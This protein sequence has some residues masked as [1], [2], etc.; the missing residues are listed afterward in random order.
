MNLKKYIIALSATVV[1]WGCES[2]FLDINDD[3]NNPTEAPLSGLLTNIEVG[4]TGSLG[5]GSNSG[6]LSNYVTHLVGQHVTRG[7]LAD[8]GLTG[9]DFGVTNSWNNLY[10][11]ALQDIKQVEELAPAQE[12]YNYLGVAQILKAYIYSNMVDVWGN[13]PY[14]GANLGAANI[15]PTYDNGAVIYDSCFAL[16][17]QGIANLERTSAAGSLLSSGD[18]FFLNVS[19]ANKAD[20]WIRAANTLKLRLYTQITNVEDVSSQVSALLADNMLMQ[21][22]TDLELQYGSSSNP[23]NRNPLYAGE[24]ATAGSAHYIDPFF[25]EIMSGIN[26]FFPNED[27]PYTANNVIDPRIPYYF[28]N[29]MSTAESPEN[30]PAYWD[31]ATGFLGIYGFSFNIDPNEGFD[32]ASSQTI[33]G[34]WPGGGAVD[35]G[36][37]VNASFNGPGDTPQRLLTYYNL[38]FNRAELALNGFTSEDPRQMF[39][40]GMNAA[41]DK[42]DAYASASGASAIPAATRSIYTTAV[43]GLYDAAASDAERLEIIMIE[44]WKAN[45]G[46]GVVAYNDYR[47]TGFPR[48]HDGDTDNLSQTDRQREY[49]VSLPWNTNALEINPNAPSQKITATSRVFWD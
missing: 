32:Q 35:D 44:K 25:Y 3:P 16:L 21:P 37:G 18:V 5:M 29:Q 26:S 36:L 12:A 7:N 1:F 2:N 39:I 4:M 19:E 9:T 17:D 31:G 49:P 30:P 10:R 15:S 34:L 46:M 33:I 8:Y 23:D 14:T 22:G 38:L 43:T 47:R 27:N 48:L 20:A 24:W 11:V 41:F 40:D 13:V 45:Y 6:G 42:L 28:Y